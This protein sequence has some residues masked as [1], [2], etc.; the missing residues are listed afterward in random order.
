MTIKSMWRYNRLKREM[1]RRGLRIDGMASDKNCVYV[2]ASLNKPDHYIGRVF[3][4][5]DGKETYPYFE[6]DKPSNCA[7]PLITEGIEL[8]TSISNTM[9]G[10]WKL[11]DGR[12][13]F[14]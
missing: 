13:I 10:Y 8:A 1:T 7:L 3:Y 14:R 6:A 11:K 2:K 5:R 9:N 12:D 4:G